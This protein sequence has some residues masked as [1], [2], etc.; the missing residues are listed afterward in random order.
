MG[1]LAVRKGDANPHRPKGGQRSAGSGEHKDSH[2]NITGELRRIA[3][4]KGQR[5]LEVQES[6]IHDI[7]EQGK[8]GSVVTFQL[9]HLAAGLTNE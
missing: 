5:A 7:E 2:W 3:D 9:V 8:A 4:G 1:E 6:S